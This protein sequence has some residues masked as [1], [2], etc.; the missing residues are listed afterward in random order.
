MIF[1]QTDWGWLTNQ[2][3]AV[4]LLVAI[5]LGFWRVLTWT[6]ANEVIPMKD[7]A[8]KHL[9]T[10]GV[11]LTEATDSLKKI[12]VKLDVVN[13]RTTELLKTHEGFFAESLEDRT[14]IHEA[15]NNVKNRVEV[16]ENRS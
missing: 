12:N 10:V 2:G 8:V 14:K 6:G 7:S 13:D 16:L 1:A 9:E 15:I 11:T 5:G 3:L 4:G